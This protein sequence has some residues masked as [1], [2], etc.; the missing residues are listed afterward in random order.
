MSMDKIHA[1]LVSTQNRGAILGCA[2]SH[3]AKR[4]AG[5]A[6]G[7]SAPKVERSE[8]SVLMSLWACQN[9][10]W[11]NSTRCVCEHTL[12]S[13]FLKVQ[14]SVFVSKNAPLLTEKENG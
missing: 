4:Y 13:R 2:K 3:T 11:V 5:S 10:Y 8:R 9:R 1:L 14:I 7:K 6:E 12:S